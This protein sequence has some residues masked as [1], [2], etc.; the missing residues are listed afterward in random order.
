MG[1]ISDLSS[2]QRAFLVPLIC[3]A[4][5]MYFALWGYKPQ[6]ELGMANTAVPSEV[7]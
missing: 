5:V 6:T 7:Q 2:I 1:R 3:Y 4:Y